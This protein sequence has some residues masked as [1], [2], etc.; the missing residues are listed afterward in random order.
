MTPNVGSADRW[1]RIVIGLMLII[2]PLVTGLAIFANPIA[3]WGALVVG[4]ILVLTALTSTCPIYSALGLST[5][6]AGIR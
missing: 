3:Y 5:R 2:A 1:V 4:V 6:K